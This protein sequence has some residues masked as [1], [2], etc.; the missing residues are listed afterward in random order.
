[1]GPVDPQLHLGPPLLCRSVAPHAAASMEIDAMSS[2]AVEEHSRRSGHG[3]RRALPAAVRVELPCQLVVAGCRLLVLVA[4]ELIGRASSGRG[5]MGASS[6]CNIE[7]R[8]LVPPPAVLP[9]FTAV[10]PSALHRARSRWLSAR[11]PRVDRRD[12][13]AGAR[14]HGGIH[15]DR[16]TRGGTDQEARHER[17]APTSVECTS[18]SAHAEKGT[19]RATRTGR[20]GIESECK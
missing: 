9:P 13:G 2:A 4:D 7:E 6:A 14:G 19:L 18:W 3:G 15:S 17:V 20:G 10:L 1:M 12:R 5:V 11:P 16:R 8:P